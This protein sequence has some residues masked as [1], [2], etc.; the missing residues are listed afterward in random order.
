[1]GPHLRAEE[2]RERQSRIVKLKLHVTQLHSGVAI[3]FNIVMLCKF[4][5]NVFTCSN[6]NAGEG[7]Q[8]PE[9]NIF[10]IFH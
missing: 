5:N 2:R 9:I 6:T 3:I 8:G 1:M 4:W 7:L 10:D